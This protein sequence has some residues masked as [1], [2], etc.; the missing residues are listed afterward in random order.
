MSMVD[1]KPLKDATDLAKLANQ[2][3]KMTKTPP[4]VPRE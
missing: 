3:Q 2:A 1:I 4:S